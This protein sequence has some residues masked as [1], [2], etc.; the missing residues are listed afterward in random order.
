V[1]TYT[2]GSDN[3]AAIGSYTPGEDGA[4]FQFPVRKNREEPGGVLHEYTL[5]ES[6]YVSGSFD[7]DSTT[8]SISNINITLRAIQ[9]DTEFI[10]RSSTTIPLPADPFIDPATGTGWQISNYNYQLTNATVIS[11]TQIAFSTPA[12]PL[13]QAP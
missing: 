10:S 4:I 2:F 3:P 8:N 11:P 13:F 12:P 7:T 1:L 6:F 9:G 5:R